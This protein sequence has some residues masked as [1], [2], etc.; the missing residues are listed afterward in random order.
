MSHNRI[1][2]YSQ[3]KTPRLIYIFH[4]M[5]K[6]LLGLHMEIITDR[7]AI[8]DENQP[9]IAYGNPGNENDFFVAADDLLF[10]RGIKDIML[11]F[12]NYND[13][14]CFFQTFHKNSAFPFDIFAASFYLVSRYEEYLPYI[15]DDYGRFSA[16]Q[17]IAFQKGFLN[18]PLVNIW[19]IDLG[20]KL[21]A[22]FPDLQIQNTQFKYISTIDIDAAYAYKQKGFW[23]TLGGYVKNIRD[24][25]WTEIIDRTQ[26]L[27]GKREDPFDSFDYIFRLHHKF[28]LKPIFFV[29]F[30]DYGNNDKNLPTY[31]R[32]FQ[33]LIRRLV[34]YGH[35]GIHP[36]FTSNSIDGKVKNEIARLSKVIH[37][38]ITKSRQHFLMLT[39]PETYNKLIEL[40]ITEDYTMGFASQPGFRA[41]IAS[42]YYFYNL[43]FE[44][45]TSL[46]LFPFAYMEGT[47]RDYLNLRPQDAL[48]QINMLIDEVKNVGGTFISLWHNESMGGKNRWVGWPEIYKKSLGYALGLKVGE[49]AEE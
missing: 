31:N 21:K 45:V 6:N 19:A 17:S 42:P 15:K 28:N 16:S 18:K 30:A 34:D 4:L 23:R 38:E 10:E 24:W 25:Q 22:H 13:N 40:G 36:S 46:K 11:T 37:S 7:N 26:V 5:L 33:S 3:R 32:K 27:T 49:E 41:S 8:T 43:E 2:V 29:L 48:N 44:M 20:Q 35:V 1:I 9:V 14:P 47:L 39:M 12:G